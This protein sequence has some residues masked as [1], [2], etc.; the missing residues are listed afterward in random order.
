M[1]E[2]QTVYVVDDDAG[3]RKSLGMLLDSAGLSAEPFESAKAF[4]AGFDSRRSGCLVLDIKMPEMSGLELQEHLVKAGITIPIIVISAHADVTSAVR[5]MK[6]G[7][8]DFIEKPYAPEKIL[9]KIQEALDFDQQNRAEREWRAS[10]QKLMQAVTERERE[11]LDLVVAGKPSKQIA[12]ELG[13]T[14]STVDNHRAKL[15]KKLKAET[16]ADLLRITLSADGISSRS[17]LK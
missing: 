6:M 11:I 16:T 1:I 12:S 2:K 9:D 5:A 4:L 13:I 17:R 10:V 14:V 15:L 8:F 7:S 3:M